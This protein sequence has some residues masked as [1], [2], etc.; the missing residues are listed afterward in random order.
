MCVCV[1]VCVRES[2]HKQC[3]EYTHLAVLHVYFLKTPGS[4]HVYIL[5]LTAYLLQGGAPVLH[6]ITSNQCA[7]R[8]QHFSCICSTVYNFSHRAHFS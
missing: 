1:C 5:H 8:L 4:H 2:L 3:H 6:T 7:V